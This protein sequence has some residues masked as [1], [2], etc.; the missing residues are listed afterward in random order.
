[1]RFSLVHPSRDRLAMARQA[2]DEWTGGLSGRHSHEYLL[3]VDTDDPV[4]AG[5]RELAVSRGI[6][7]VLGRNRS[8][9][10]AVNRAAAQATGDVIVAISD[11]FG[12]PPEWDLLLAAVLGEQRDVAVHVHDGNQD[13]ITTLPIVG[14]AFYV[15]HGFLY[16]PEYVSWYADE[17]LTETARREGKLID[18][19]HI[20]FPHRHY[21]LGLNPVDATYLRENSD[22]ARWRGETVLAKRRAA[23]FGRRPPSVSLSLVRARLELE[24]RC[25]T[26]R[27]RLRRWR[28]Q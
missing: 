3:S 1:V 16:Y 11:D 15:R 10:D 13:R 6:R 21:T 8:V 18:A 14:R 2:I 22:A 25:R 7:L 5:Y 19:R 27:R 26:L 28:P 20:V 9:V 24:G 17:D 4:V 23:D 12:C